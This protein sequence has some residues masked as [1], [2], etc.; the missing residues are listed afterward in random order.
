M[1]C[2]IH[3]FVERKIEGTWT[4]EKEVEMGRNS[5]LFGILAGVRSWDDPEFIVKGLPDD[6]SSELHKKFNELVLGEIPKYHTP[7][8]LKFE[9]VF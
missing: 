4:F 7:S 3:V 1:G 5:H 6:L 8:Y 2:D 9:E